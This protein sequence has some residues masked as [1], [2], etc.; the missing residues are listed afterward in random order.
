MT[1]H[2]SVVPLPTLSVYAGTKAAVDAWSSALRIELE[3]FDVKVITLTPG[4][5]IYIDFIFLSFFKLLL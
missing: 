5:I 1:S 2:C 3:K 4:M